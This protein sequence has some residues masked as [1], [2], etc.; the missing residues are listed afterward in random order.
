MSSEELGEKW[1]QAFKR[2][3]PAG[4]EGIKRYHCMIK[5]HLSKQKTSIYII[6]LR[7]SEAFPTQR[8]RFFLI[9]ESIFGKCLMKCDR[10][11][12]LTH[13]STSGANRISTL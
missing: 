4:V 7:F 11:A 10:N 1:A 6:A 12:I 3:F 13:N 9:S 5:R 2:R 8:W